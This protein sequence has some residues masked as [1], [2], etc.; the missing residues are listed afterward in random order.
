MVFYFLCM[1]ISCV[2]LLPVFC[3]KNTCILHLIYLC[4]CLPD[5]LPT[6]HLLTCTVH[7]RTAYLPK[8]FSCLPVI[9]LAVQ[10]PPDHLPSYP[11]AYQFHLLPFIWLIVRLPTCPSAYLSSCLPVNLSTCPSA[12]PASL[13]TRPFS[14]LP[15]NLPN[16][17]SLHV[18]L[19]TF[20][21]VYLS[22]WLPFHLGT[23]Q[24]VYLFICLSAHLPICI[25][26]YLS[27]RIP[28]NL[29]N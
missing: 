27:I 11:F 6:S 13:P 28:I 8:G 25:Y 18:H 1:Q 4:S 15:V 19:P 21:S 23:C 9:C 20:P 26:A 2:G 14:F 10:I 7:L 17:T 5:Y 3:L 24:S 22:F 29:H 16:C 12:Y